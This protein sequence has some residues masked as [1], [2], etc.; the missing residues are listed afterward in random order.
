MHA[1]V[2]V[3]DLGRGH[4]ELL[5][6]EYLVKE[7]EGCDLA[8]GYAA[9]EVDKHALLPRL[10]SNRTASFGAEELGLVLREILRSGQL[11]Q[12]YGRLS[13]GKAYCRQSLR[14]R[15]LA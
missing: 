15:R 11:L 10:V 5:V 6:F 1:V 8:V 9:D 3:D 12:L 13:N 2:A 4:Y 14:S 7:A